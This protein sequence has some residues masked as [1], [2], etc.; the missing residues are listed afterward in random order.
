MISSGA[1]SRC[2]F[3]IKPMLL[4]ICSAPE[5]ASRQ[6]MA[7][8]PSISST[9]VTLIT[10]V[11][12]EPKADSLDDLFL[13]ILLFDNAFSFRKGHNMLNWRKDTKK[14]A[15]GQILPMF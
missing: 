10:V 3:T 8:M 12:L 14:S 11:S 15:S 2:T 9:R 5:R 7:I 1:A 4:R 6:A 13:V